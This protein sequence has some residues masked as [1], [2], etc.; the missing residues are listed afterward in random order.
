MWSTVQ[1][2]A[3]Q[4]G[5][6]GLLGPMTVTRTMPLWKSAFL[7]QLLEAALYHCMLFFIAE[8]GGEAKSAH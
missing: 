3:P 1:N 2:T 5:L 4:S 6:S 7:W 8:F